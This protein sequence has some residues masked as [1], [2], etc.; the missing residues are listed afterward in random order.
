MLLS[1][2]EKK[3]REP[4]LLKKIE[5]LEMELQQALI[6]ETNSEDFKK[7]IKTLSKGNR[8]LSQTIIAERKEFQAL[9]DKYTHLLVEFRTLKKQE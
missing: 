6:N 1:R 2:C 3:S 7:T 5:M 9:Q 4:E 8:E